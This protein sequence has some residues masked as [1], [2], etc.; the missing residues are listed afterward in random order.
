MD[1]RLT[2]PWQP[3][4]AIPVVAAA[5]AT[6]V[7]ASVVFAAVLG[8]SGG[9]TLLLTA[10]AFQASLAGFTLLWVAFRYRPW[11]PA[12]GLRSDRTAKDVAVGAWSGA[13]IFVGAAFLVLPVLIFLWRLVSGG[14]PPAINQ[15]I[16]PLDPTPVQIVLSVVAV[17]VA[18]PVGEELFFRGFLFG[19]LRARLSFLPAAA[20]SGLVFG[21]FHVQPLLVAVMVVVGIALAFL[22]ERRRSL[23][24]C[25][26]AHAIFNL[27]GYTLIVMQR[28]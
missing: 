9:S 18:A 21:L 25:I 7:L 10:I 16:L 6:A 23:A 1:Q 19:S 15:P 4:E 22:Y 14:P 2:A 3:W 13:A 26:A 11:L 12:L 24:V 27:I 17:I 5:V 8:G 28:L 20:I